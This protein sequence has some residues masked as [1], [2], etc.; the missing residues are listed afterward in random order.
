MTSQQAALPVLL[1]GASGFV[2]GY[3]HRLLMERAG[4]RPIVVYGALNNTGF[5][6]T[7]RQA[8]DDAVR[9]LRPAAIIHLAAIAAP[10]QAHAD[11][12]RAWDVNLT[13]TMNLAEA[14]MRHVPDA[15]FIHAG[16]SEAYGASFN[17]R[18]GAPIT[19]DVALNPV[20]TYAASKAAADLMI[21]QM[22]HDG[23]RAIR[24]RPFNHTGPGQA[25]I[26]VV[27]AFAR[28]IA[29]IVVND[30]EAVIRVGNLEAQRDFLDVRDVARAYVDAALGAGEWRPGLVFNLSSG[31]PRSIGSLLN[32][33]IAA[34]GR[35]ITVEQDPD[36]M[37][38]N[39][40]PIAV[41]ANNAAAVHL[42]WRP[43]I[44][45]ATTLVDVLG[46]WKMRVAQASPA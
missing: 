45:F 22:S 26:F 42:N 31:T 8:T 5:D 10:R 2:G 20:N 16:S 41:G 23:L 33:L 32:A 38:T 24:F 40:L 30:A 39:D 29:E 46:D 36:R 3:V 12:R 43:E 13:G 35:S 6:L 44:D 14:V 28:Q 37:R 1:T 15:R 9:A 11:P 19:E 34:S 27:P 25:D 18:Q 21:G 17:G 4:G 7:D